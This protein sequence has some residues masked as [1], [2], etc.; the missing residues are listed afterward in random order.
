MDNGWEEIRRLFNEAL[1]LKP[2]ERAPF[3]RNAC[4]GKDD[5]RNE[6]ASLLDAHA[7]AKNFMQST[8][9]PEHQS[10]EQ[11]RIREPSSKPNEENLPHA[12]RYQ[13]DGEY[14]RGGLGR[15]LKAYDRNL[16]R[17]VA[18]KELLHR[19][20]SLEARFMR[21]AIITA[22]L[23]HPAIVPVHEV[24]RW[25]DGR[26]FYAMKMVSGSSLAQVIKE[27]HTL[28]ERLTLLSHVIAV[29]DA[30]AYAHQQGIIHRDLKPSNVLIGPFGETVVIDWGLAADLN[31]SL[32]QSPPSDYKDVVDSGVTV[33]G[34][35]MGTPEYMSREQAEGRR[36]DE[37]ADVYAIGAMLY[38][39]IAGAPPF[40]GKSS[41]EVLAKI[42]ADEPRPIEVR[43]PRV[44]PEL[45]AIIRKALATSRSDRYPTARELTDD[46]KRFTTGQLVTAQSYT[47]F[48]LFKRWAH[49]HRLPVIMCALFLLSLTIIAAMSVRRIIVARDFSEQQRRIAEHR[50]DEL[51]MEKARAMLETDPTR[52]LAWLKNFAVP[53]KH[54]SAV[55]ELAA[56][57]I[58]R[59]VTKHIFG[60]G[61]DVMYLTFTTGGRLLSAG[62]NGQVH[63]WD[64]DSGKHET[65][66]HDPLLR[67]VA[68][69]TDGQ[70]VATGGASGIISL[71]KIGT[72]EKRTFNGAQGAIIQLA[73]L[74]GRTTLASGGEDGTVQLW[75]ILAGKSR[76]LNRHSNVVWKI[77]VSPDGSRLAS[78]G[79]DNRVLVTA[80]ATGQLITIGHH[81]APVTSLVFSNNG[82]LVASGAMDNT[83]RLWGKSARESR[84]F[85]GHQ[86][87]VVRLAF[88]PNGR[89]LASA[90]FDKSVRLWNLSDGSSTTLNGHD[91]RVKSISFSKDGSLLASGSSEGTV[92]VWDLRS[93]QSFLLRGHTTAVNWAA[94]SD[95]NVL[96]TAGYD[97][98]VRVWQLDNFLSTPQLGHSNIVYNIV[99]S[100]DGSQL[101]SS[102]ADVTVRLW[103]WP[104]GG[105]RS[106][107]R[108]HSREVSYV[109]FSPDGKKIASSGKDNAVRIWDATTEREELVLRHDAPVRRAV[110]AS[111]QNIVS[112]TAKDEIYLWQ[113]GTGTRRPL[114]QDPN[115]STGFAVSD[116]GTQLAYGGKDGILR[117]SY[118]GT[119]NPREFRGE[120][121]IR[122]IAFSP[123][124]NNRI[125]TSSSDSTVR[126]WD[127][128]T[129]TSQVLPHDEV[130]I[131]RLAFSKDGHFVAGSDNSNNVHC[132][133][134]IQG[135]SA[136]F[137]GHL[138]PIRSLAFSNH[139][140]QFA[141]CSEDKTV[142][143]WD[144]R[145]GLVRTLRG[146]LNYVMG[147]SFSPR[148]DALVS[149]G[150]DRSIRHWKLNEGLAVPLSSQY[151]RQWLGSLTGME[152][153]VSDMW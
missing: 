123:I 99:F 54:W 42:L 17:T 5:L 65:Q 127:V 19:D 27:K 14:A 83:V 133:D 80:V 153:A 76:L 86:D 41:E 73:F 140:S 8:I 117:L 104:T 124:D 24:R 98:T 143:I 18:L 75:D 130:V 53:E 16:G 109:A 74:P 57:A 136:T 100:P 32:S 46:L 39:L 146:H 111:G 66:Q 103:D 9:P 29:A 62:E 23:Q 77:A 36:V 48:L 56:D 82:D 52:V 151:L 11:A 84:V 137:A 4:R 115:G 7:Q 113:L 69:S 6:V 105:L 91:D 152:L 93:G 72:G 13:V 10:C 40:E 87:A 125:I 95:G 138:G 37:R 28:D 20:E 145:V 60:H 94:F 97:K 1:Q 149:A 131:T 22:R 68:A 61:S 132:W 147:I 129:G 49:R 34:S 150:A 30:I 78:A 21:E 139:G 2:D 141:T 51:R 35:I 107:F 120:G 101:A 118:L 134:I 12:E 15:V 119:E 110:F 31:H 128:A 3:L 50:N 47:P 114:Q 45:A 92:R 71:W 85:R 43:E 96:A 89:T 25:A 44:P 90:S 112:L 26:P 64:V 135:T 38:H 126:L 33:V 122:E 106:V 79:A 148:D 144:P 102:S 108:G 88:S 81:D 55:R 59:G 58:S 67:A 121:E 70:W 142:R 116:D 63:L